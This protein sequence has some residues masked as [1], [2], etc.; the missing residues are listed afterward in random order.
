MA[1]PLR[2]ILAIVELGGY[3]DFSPLY[4]AAGFAP[5]HANSMR[6]A[7]TLLKK[8]KPSVIVA[9]FNFQSDFRDRSSS[10]ESL[11]ATLQRQGSDA[12]VV[13]LFEP[14]YRGAFEQRLLSRWSVDAALPFPVEAR[15]LER[16]LTDVSRARGWRD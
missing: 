7:L 4:R 1:E 5:L 13:V 8:E 12:A 14:E 2:K 6:K 11:M 10:L 15:A 9:E 16:A 3:P